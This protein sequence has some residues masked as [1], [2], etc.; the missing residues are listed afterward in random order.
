MPTL[1]LSDMELASAA[2]GMRGMVRQ[3]Q[4][5]AAR[6]ENPG[7]RKL[8]EDSARSH[9]V[10]VNKFE[11]ARATNPSKPRGHRDRL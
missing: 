10:L 8:F 6:Q 11:G 3:A 4:E 9:Q 5:D 2:M 7:M 1:E